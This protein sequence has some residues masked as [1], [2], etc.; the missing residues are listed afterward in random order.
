MILRENTVPAP[1]LA[2]EAACGSKVVAERDIERLQIA[3]GRRHMLRASLHPWLTAADIVALGYPPERGLSPEASRKRKQ[4]ELED[5]AAF[6]AEGLIVF[7]AHPDVRRWRVLPPD[8]ETLRTGGG[9][10]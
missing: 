4:R 2:G 5:L 10:A 6:E 8:M 3:H 1:T 9:K 7:E